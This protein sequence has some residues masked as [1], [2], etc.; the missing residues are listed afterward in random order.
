M[1]IRISWNRTRRLRRTDQWSSLEYNV[2][3]E[4]KD[5]AILIVVFSI[6]SEW[7]YHGI[8]GRPFS[9]ALFQMVPIFDVLQQKNIWSDLTFSGVRGWG[10][11][12][13]VIL[14]FCVTNWVWMLPL[15]KC[16]WKIPNFL[17]LWTAT[18]LILSSFMKNYC[19]NNYISHQQLAKRQINFWANENGLA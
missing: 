6:L 17:R 13:N 8:V 16:L 9:I 4:V 15:N 7:S 3:N 11:T 1:P 18:S 10:W 5:F 14:T 2:W 19:L 12:K